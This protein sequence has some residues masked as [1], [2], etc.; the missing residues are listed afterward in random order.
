MNR[1]LI[2]SFIYRISSL[3]YIIASKVS[4]YLDLQ[5]CKA[6]LVSFETDVKYKNLKLHTLNLKTTISGTGGLY[7]FIFIINNYNRFFW[8]TTMSREFE[9]ITFGWNVF[10]DNIQPGTD[11]I[12]DTNLREWK[13]VDINYISS[14]FLP[15]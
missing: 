1:H 13:P 2:K 6:N 11:Y 4:Y 3:D 14:R 8:F 15:T 7:F 9:E 10:M 5:K 12:F